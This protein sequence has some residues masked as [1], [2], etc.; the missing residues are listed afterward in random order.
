MLLGL[1]FET[2]DFPFSI[3]HSTQMKNEKRFERASPLECLLFS[4]RLSRS[5]PVL[6]IDSRQPFEALC[7]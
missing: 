7:L 2:T 4:D 1:K 3:F 6:R 5:G